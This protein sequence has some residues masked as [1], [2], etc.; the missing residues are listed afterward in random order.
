MTIITLII[1][2]E[3]I[4]KLVC[5]GSHGHK[6]HDAVIFANRSDALEWLKTNKFKPA[7]GEG[8]AVFRRGIFTAAIVSTV[9]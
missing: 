3:P 7:N 8:D 1:T 5:N 6:A 2:G 4:S 9:N